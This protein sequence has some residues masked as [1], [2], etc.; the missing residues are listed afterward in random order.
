MKIVKIILSIMPLAILCGCTYTPELEDSI[1]STPT[2]VQS[3]VGTC[4]EI[5]TC[6]EKKIE[7]EQPLIP[8]NFWGNYHCA[9]FPKWSLILDES[10]N[11]GK[12]SRGERNA[13]EI[14]EFGVVFLYPYPD[15]KSCRIDMRIPEYA[16]YKKRF[17]AIREMENGF[18]EIILDVGSSNEMSLG[19]T[20]KRKRD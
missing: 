17:L 8:P 15:A 10:E 16:N 13:E 19:K 4:G 12:L 7:C 6:K 1:L 2:K 14:I 20:F 9:E 3:G 18:F 11:S 5:C